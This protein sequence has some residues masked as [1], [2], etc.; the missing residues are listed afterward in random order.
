MLFLQTGFSQVKV[1]DTCT[2]SMDKETLRRMIILLIDRETLAETSEARDLEIKNLDAQL[3]LKDTQNELLQNE[4]SSCRD[5][6][7]S[8]RQKWWDNFL[9][10]M[11]AGVLLISITVAALN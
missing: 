7:N 9:T 1:I 8:S 6:L 3:G 11:L 2:V 10:G 5:L 4:L